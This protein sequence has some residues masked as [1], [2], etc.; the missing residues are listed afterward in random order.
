MGR[1][2][3]EVRFRE[4]VAILQ[5]HGYINNLGGEKIE[6]RCEAV[7]REGYRKF[8]INLRHSAI[9]NSI[10]VSILIGVIDR[11]QR[12]RGLVCFSD[13]TVPT[14][15]VFD[16]MG[17]TRHAPVFPTEEEAVRHALGGTA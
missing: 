13:L 17:L 6:E 5:T 9:I 1:F 2:R 11:V 10:G 7:L 16:L 14:A 12:A 3:V 4:D 15:E 8:I